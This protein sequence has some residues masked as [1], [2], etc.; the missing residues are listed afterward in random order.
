MQYYNQIGSCHNKL[1]AHA[2]LQYR[3]TIYIYI[4][5]Y[6]Y[7]ERERERRTKR[8]FGFHDSSSMKYIKPKKH[9]NHFL[10]HASFFGT[11]QKQYA[12]AKMVVGI[13]RIGVQ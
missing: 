11:W 12:S 10:K 4:Y 1:S 5:I 3:E 6:I 9:K 13:K 2:P 7:I 8:V